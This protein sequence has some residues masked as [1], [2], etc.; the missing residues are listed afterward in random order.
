MQ[1]Q[2]QKSSKHVATHIALIYLLAICLILD[3]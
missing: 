3:L 1:L 2:Y